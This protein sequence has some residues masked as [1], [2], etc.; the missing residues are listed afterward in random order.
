MHTLSLIGI[1]V[2]MAFL[3][4]LIIGSGITL[5]E[6]WQNVLKGAFMLLAAVFCILMLTGCMLV[7]C[8]NCTFYEPKTNE[9]EASDGLYTN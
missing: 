3:T 5:S 6:K 2:A 7:K 4:G 1:Y 9:A 8:D